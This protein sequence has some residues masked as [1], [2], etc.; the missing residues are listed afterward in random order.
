MN[1]ALKIVRFD[2]IYANLENILK[3][4]QEFVKNIAQI[5]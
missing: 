1:G 3:N 5:R 4:L 2:H